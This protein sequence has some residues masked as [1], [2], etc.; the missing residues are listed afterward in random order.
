MTNVM[1]AFVTVATVSVENAEQDVGGTGG[2]GGVYRVG[3]L[4]WFADVCAISKTNM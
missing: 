1:R 4:V 2:E 3:V